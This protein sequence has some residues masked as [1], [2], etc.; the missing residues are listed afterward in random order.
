M[1][2]KNNYWIIAGCV[3]LFT[4][5][6]HLIGGQLSI[7]DPLLESSMPLQPKS[8]MLAAWHLITVFLFLSSYYFLRFGFGKYH[9]EPDYLIQMMSYA[10]LGFG[11]VF[12]IVSIVQGVFAPQW[13]LL[14]PIGVFGLIGKK[15]TRKI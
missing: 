3:A 12:I 6:L 2:Q 11:V 8:E 14:L 7:V 1:S 4:S 15:L 5:F 10:Y 13:I 9:K